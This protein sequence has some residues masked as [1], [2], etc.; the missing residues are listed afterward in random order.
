[1]TSVRPK[2]RPDA[3]K[4]ISGWDV[5]TGESVWLTPQGEWSSNIDHAAIL[6]GEKAE[7]ALVRAKGEEG[8]IVEPYF[9]EI[10]E[11]GRPCGREALRERIRMNGPSHSTSRAITAHF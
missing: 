7:N 8:K 6:T 9:V 1:M 4:A 10:C 5:I 3:L 2:L 11:N